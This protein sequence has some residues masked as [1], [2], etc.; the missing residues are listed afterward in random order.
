VPDKKYMGTYCKIGA[1][2]AGN[3]ETD[4]REKAGPSQIHD[5]EQ[6]ESRRPN[7]GDKEQQ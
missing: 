2:R 1:T 4:K 6:E 5:E 3:K 7:E